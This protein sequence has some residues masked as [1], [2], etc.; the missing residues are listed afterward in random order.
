M[1]GAVVVVDQSLALEP[2]LPD[3][4]P[5]DRKRVDDYVA[6]ASADATLRAY[7]SDWRLFCAWCAEAGYQS[8]P[9]S[10]D[11]ARRERLHAA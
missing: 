8:L 9:A 5:D 10:P 11:V 6:R 7:R 4:S 1:A 2:Y 3:L